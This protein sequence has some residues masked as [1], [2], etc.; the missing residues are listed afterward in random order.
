MNTYNRY[1]YIVY[2]YHL[3]SFTLLILF[4][5][6]NKIITGEHAI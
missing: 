4:L 3:K 5:T 1:R 6:D 2:N